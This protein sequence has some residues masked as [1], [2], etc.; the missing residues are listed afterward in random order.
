MEA[1][2]REVLHLPP[3]LNNNP[4]FSNSNL[5]M[6][7]TMKI[8]DTGSF[9]LYLYFI[10]IFREFQFCQNFA[11]NR[12]IILKIYIYLFFIQNHDQR[13]CRNYSGTQNVSTKP[14][15]N[16]IYQ[17]YEIK[18]R[19]LVYISFTATNSPNAISP[20]CPLASQQQQQPPQN[21]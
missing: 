21:L 6:L 3:L 19:F 5:L 11:K 12:K 1:I 7:N 14:R 20:S 4:S 16:N 18:E 2:Y 17:Y 10:F 9:F 13:R 8:W 15:Y